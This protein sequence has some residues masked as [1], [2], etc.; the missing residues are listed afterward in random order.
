[1]LYDVAVVGLGGMGSAVLAH[2][3]KRGARAIGLEQFAH[4]HELGASSGRTRIIRKVYFEHPSYVPLLKRAYELWRELEAE[5]STK[6]VDLIGLL[7]VGAAGSEAIKGTLLS[8][9]TYDLPLDELDAS[10]IAKKYPGVS[11]HPNEI[12]LLERDAG[13]VYPEKAID[14]HLRVAESCGAE[15][16]FRTAVRGWETKADRCRIHFGN[17]DVI[18]A[19]K[20][21]VCA[22]PWSA[23]LL[24][25]AGVPLEVQRNVQVW[26]DPPTHAFD[27]GRLPAYLVD[28]AEFGTPLYGF[29][30]TSDGLKAALH[31]H[32]D[33]TQPEELDRDV[34][35]ED[36]EAVRNALESWMPG[37]GTRFAWGKVCMYTLTPDRHFVIDR[38]PADPRVVIAGGFSGHG[39]KFTPVV[40]EIATDLALDGGT[41]HDI[42]FLSATRFATVK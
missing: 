42:A 26:F 17:D 31:A 4:L 14:A 19:R 9:R 11:P 7:T 27:V 29:P 23:P 24:E 22:G 6:L 2:A 34:H 18:E 16:R 28:R 39:F 36:V 10:E 12:G 35:D 20:I 5:S 25:G 33:T 8:A 15:M 3:A 30:K 38:D 13:M 1:M 41:R 32:G 37:A 21:V 40:G